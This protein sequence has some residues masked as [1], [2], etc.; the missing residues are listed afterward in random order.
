MCVCV[1]GGR[2]RCV[3]VCC[4]FLSFFFLF[5]FYLGFVADGGDGFDWGWI[6]SGGGYGFQS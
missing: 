3:M 5:F 6:Y 1:C 4:G 2:F